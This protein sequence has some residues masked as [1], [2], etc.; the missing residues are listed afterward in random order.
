MWRRISGTQIGVNVKSTE[1]R[2]SKMVELLNDVQL[3]EAQRWEARGQAARAD[4]F[5][6]VVVAIARGVRSLAHWI[7]RTSRLPARTAH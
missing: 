6:D 5:A 4:A 1:K 2:E 3:T 7:E